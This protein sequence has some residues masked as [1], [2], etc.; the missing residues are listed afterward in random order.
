MVDYCES[1]GVPIVRVPVNLYLEFSE[2]VK[3]SYLTFWNMDS[4]EY[5]KRAAE[6]GLTITLGHAS[7]STADFEEWITAIATPLMEL[8]MLPKVRIPEKPVGGP[9]EK[10]VV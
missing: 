9:T 7:S 8:G 2:T 5:Q 1:H 3:L 6:A 4:Y 10:V